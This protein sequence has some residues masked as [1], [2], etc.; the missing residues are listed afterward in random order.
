[1]S[2]HVI[3]IPPAALHGLPIGLSQ[4]PGLE[5]T[6]SACLLRLPNEETR[7]ARSSATIGKPITGHEKDTEYVT[8]QYWLEVLRL[9]RGQQVIHV[10]QGL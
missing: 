10:N 5:E 1:M 6:Y 9:M 7:T 3:F 2:G 4:F 8:Q